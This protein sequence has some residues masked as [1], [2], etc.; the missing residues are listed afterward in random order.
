MVL[1]AAYLNLTGP[2]AVHSYMSKIEVTAEIEEKDV[3][4]F[5]SLGWKEV[6]GGLKSGNIACTFK[7]DYTDSA[8]DDDLWTVFIAG[9]PI[10]YEARATQS[11]VGPNNPKYSGNVL[12]KSVQPIMGSV[13]DV[14]EQSVTWP[15]SGAITRAEA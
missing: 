10:A 8:L 13:G 15:T 1:T 12:V 6:T 14:A 3:T 7:N 5:T 9:V 2:G 11:S 4:V